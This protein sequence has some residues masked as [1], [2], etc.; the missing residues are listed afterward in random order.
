MTRTCPE[1]EQEIGETEKNC[2]KCGLDLDEFSEEILSNLDRGI[3]IVEKRR[4]KKTPP[5][6]PP[7]PKPQ[8]QTKPNFWKAL[9]R[10]N[11]EEKSGK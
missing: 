10:K 3:S 5:E 6:P 11:G 4:K 1:C 7:A 9:G 2:P 8:P